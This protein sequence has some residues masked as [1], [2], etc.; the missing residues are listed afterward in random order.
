[1]FVGFQEYLFDLKGQFGNDL[2][3]DI[4]LGYVLSLFTFLYMLLYTKSDG[5]TAM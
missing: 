2:K 4:I 5:I 1:M 3:D